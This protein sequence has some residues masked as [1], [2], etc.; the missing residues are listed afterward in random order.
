M[1]KKKKSKQSDLDLRVKI[2]NM[3]KKKRSQTLKAADKVEVI[4]GDSDEPKVSFDQWWML[5]N[6][7][8]RLKSW[9]KEI[10]LVDFQARG[11]SKSESENKYNQALTLFG[12]KQ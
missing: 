6:K 2:K 1:A 7:R 4:T 12:I 8:V 5:V 10:I 3:E 11:L 9:M